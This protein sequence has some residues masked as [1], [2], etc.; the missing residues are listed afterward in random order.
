[1]THGNALA[2]LTCLVASGCARTG[3]VVP[4]GADRAALV[5]AI[6]S[7]GQGAVVAETPELP[8]YSTSGKVI[9]TTVKVG[10]TA[11]VV[12]AVGAVG[13]VAALGKGHCSGLGLLVTEP[14]RE[15][16]SQD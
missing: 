15:I 6:A 5:A 11:A 2:F 10:E 9:T 12:G 4:D 8:D 14:L 16:W 7:R 1:M 13:A 3:I